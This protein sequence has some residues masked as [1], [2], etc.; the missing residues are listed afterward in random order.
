MGKNNRK[1]DI[2]SQ[3]SDIME[4][5]KNKLYSILKKNKDD[6][7]SPISNIIV[8]IITIKVEIE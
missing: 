1:I 7:L 8:A 5:K 2:L 4:E 6:L 3:Q